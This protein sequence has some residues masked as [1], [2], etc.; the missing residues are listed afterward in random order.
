MTV[1]GSGEPGSSSPIAPLNGLA[2]LLASLSRKSMRDLSD[3]ELHTDSASMLP[4]PEVLGLPEVLADGIMPPT[5]RKG[6]FSFRE[7]S[8][9]GNSFYLCLI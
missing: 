3:F 4:W 5:L 7:I 2:A 9:G 8:T 6:A 1:L